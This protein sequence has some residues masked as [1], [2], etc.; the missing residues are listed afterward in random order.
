MAIMDSRGS[1]IVP[2]LMN[3]LLAVLKFEKNVD[4]GIIQNMS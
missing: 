2:G 1:A 4:F 3:S